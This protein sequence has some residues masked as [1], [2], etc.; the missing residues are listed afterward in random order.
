VLTY[1]VREPATATDD[2][3]LIVLMHGRGASRFDLEPLGSHMPAH[4]RVVFPEAPFAGS[5]WGYGPGSAWYQF[6]GRNKPEP[7][8]FSAALDALSELLAHFAAKRVVLGGF[9]QG[10]T[11]ANAYALAN[12]GSLTGALNFSG[13]LADH[14]RVV[15]DEEHVRGTSFFWGHGRQDTSIPFELAIEGRA[16]LKQAG[17]KLTAHDYDIGHWI[18]PQE[19]DDAIQ[20]LASL[21]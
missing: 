13:F 1:E 5:K 17:A 15:V 7:Q 12:P 9:S 20:W 21:I 19:L 8:S 6:L 14:P 10:G 3:P 2:A 4:A 11:M 18:E 16:Q